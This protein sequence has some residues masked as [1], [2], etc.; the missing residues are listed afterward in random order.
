M[1]LFLAPM[2]QT[3]DDLPLQKV[4]AMVARGEISRQ[5]KTALVRFDGCDVEYQLGVRIDYMPSG[6]FWAKLLCPKCGRGAQRVRLLDGVPCC[7]RCCKATGLIYRSQSVAT[8]KRY[9]V[10]APPRLAKLNSERSLFAHHH[11]GG[12]LERRRNIEFAL[13]RSRIVARQHL[14]DRA[15]DEGL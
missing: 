8:G 7:G 12:M 13:R 5:S 2:K 15:K 4:S 1:W 3:I 14:L 9:A 10:T 11:H 6:G